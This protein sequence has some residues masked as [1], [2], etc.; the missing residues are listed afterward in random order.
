MDYIDVLQDSIDT[1]INIKLFKNRK[2]SAFAHIFKS[3]L[4]KFPLSKFKNQYVDNFNSNRLK[5]SAVKAYPLHDRPRGNCDISCVK[6]YQKKIQKKQDISPIWMIIK[7]K[8]YILL[9]GAHRIVASYIEN[10]KT[11]P[12]YIITI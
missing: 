11:I 4:V 6:F 3:G 2:D 1:S 10:K 8:Q 12:A 7:N 9:D 5:K